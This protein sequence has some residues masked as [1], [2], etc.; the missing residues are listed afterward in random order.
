MIDQLRTSLRH[1]Q[2]QS[3]HPSDPPPFLQALRG[4]VEQPSVGMID[5]AVLEPEDIEQA[6]S[7]IH[8]FLRDEAFA[9]LSV[10]DAARVVELLHAFGWDIG[11]LETA[12]DRRRAV[13]PPPPPLVGAE[14]D[15]L[16]LAA[17][18]HPEGC[19]LADPITDVGWLESLRQHG[20]DVP[21]DLV[22]LLC[23][24]DGFDLSAIVVPHLPVF[25]LLPTS[26]F[27]VL[28]PRDDF[29]A[30]V[31][32]FEG[33]DSVHLSVYGDDSGRWWMAFEYDYEPE[34]RVAYDLR[35]LL[36]FGLDRMNATTAD[37]LFGGRLSWEAFFG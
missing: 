5:G 31:A 32:V 34:A 24:A 35:K 13:H 10:A 33:G 29:P 22:A 21:Q 1:P 15:A 18:T 36:R 3:R 23:V 30:R 17:K 19:E 8:G 27:D 4:R 6:A 7:A 12:L 16:R 9:L 11:D 14:V 25:S 2:R 37:E 28:E 26:S 20:V